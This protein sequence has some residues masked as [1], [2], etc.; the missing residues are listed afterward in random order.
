MIIVRVWNDQRP[1]GCGASERDRE[2][3]TLV[4]DASVAVVVQR[5]KVFDE[6]D[7]SLLKDSEIEIGIDP[8]QL[9]SDFHRVRTAD[10]CQRIGEL[11]P[12]HSSLLRHSERSA[13]LQAW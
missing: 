11:K 4:V 2:K 13:V 6:L 8:P 5:R 12:V 9:A 7:T 10:E 3:E 1:I